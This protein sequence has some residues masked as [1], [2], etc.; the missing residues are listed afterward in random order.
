MKKF[1]TKPIV[2]VGMMGS[3]KSTVGR[4][5]ARKLKLRFHDSDR[6]IEIR[7]KLS[8]VDIYNLRGKE[9]FQEKEQEILQEILTTKVAVIAVGGGAFLNQQLANLIKE[10][11]IT[12]LLS[13]DF[14]T[15]YRRV[16]RRDTRPEFNGP[17]K[18]DVLNNMLT[19]YKNI[20]NEI[21][22][23]VENSDADVSNVIETITTQL[24][25]YLQIHKLYL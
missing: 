24:K 5:L 11:A 12:I 14:S 19:Q 7:E 6:I 15:L 3:G 13:A 20:C 23:K 22:I 1:I 16:K 10:K 21:D 25:K 2:L 4:H 9:Y 8:V 17:N 18:T